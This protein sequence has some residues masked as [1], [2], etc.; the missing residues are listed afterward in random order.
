M[1]SYRSYMIS[2]FTCRSL[3]HFVFIFVY[4]VRKWPSSVLSHVKL[5]SFPTPFIEE[6]VLLS[7]YILGSW[8]V[9]RITVGLL[10]KFLFCFI[11]PPG[12]FC[13]CTILFLIIFNF[14]VYFEVG[15]QDTSH[16]VVLPK[17]FHYL[18]SFVVLYAF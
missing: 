16:F 7:L 5:P 11:G 1:F 18:G 15:D 17:C 14:V 4:A 13:A 12:C 8:S 2:G 3:I 10:L 6:I 9:D